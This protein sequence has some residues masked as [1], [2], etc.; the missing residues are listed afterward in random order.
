MSVV[1]VFIL[2]FMYLTSAKR[3]SSASL[4]ILHLPTESV[5]GLYVLDICQ[6]TQFSVARTIDASF[7]LDVTSLSFADKQIAEERRLLQPTL[8]MAES[9]SIPCHVP[10]IRIVHVFI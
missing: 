7:D 6:P 4:C 2:Y 10:Q 3:L 1:A 9:G 8:S 5:Q